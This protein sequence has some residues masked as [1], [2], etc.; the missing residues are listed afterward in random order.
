MHRAAIFALAFLAQSACANDSSNCL[1]VNVESVGTVS[2]RKDIVSGPMDGGR[3]PNG[4][5]L[6]LI[7]DVD[8]FRDER[9][10]SELVR[11]SL[12]PRY[13]P[14]GVTT[15]KPELL[16][17]E[18][19]VSCSANLETADL[20]LLAQYV[21]NGEDA[22]STRQGATAELLRRVEHAVLECKAP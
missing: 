18:P 15:C 19:V 2:I 16:L 5:A 10:G 21:P 7:L 11:L 4:P 6:G 22:T 20:S 13:S 1:R 17:K 3:G 8:R 9:A 14:V 12:W